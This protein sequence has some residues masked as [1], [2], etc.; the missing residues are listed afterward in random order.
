M[1][2]KLFSGFFDRYLKVIVLLMAL[3]TL[4]LLFFNLYAGLAAALITLGLFLLSKFVFLKQERELAAY[5]ENITE[6]MELAFRRFLEQHPLPLC[7]VDEEDNLLWCNDKFI[8]IYEKAEM[9]RSN[10]MQ[11][12]GV[13][14]ADFA[15]KNPLRVQRKDRS[16]LVSRVE[17]EEKERGVSMLYWQECSELEKLRQQYEDAA[18]CVAYVNVDNYDE[19]MGSASEE[20]RGVLM[21][22]L[23][24]SIRQWVSQYEG[25]AARVSSSQYCVMLQQK[26]LTKLVNTRFPI[27]GE[28]RS[29]ETEADFPTSLSIGV[30]CGRQTLSQLDQYALDALELALGRGG[31]QAV[32][33]SP[34]RIDYYGG[35]LQSVERRNKGRSRIMAHAL[36]QMIDR[37]DKVVV[38]GH[39]MPDPDCFG[40][41]M[42]LHRAAARCGKETLIVRGDYENSMERFYQAAEESGQY[43]FVLPEQAKAAMS[44]KTL[45]IVVDAHRPVLLEGK[46][47]LAMTDNIMLIDHH[48]RA[49]DCID[50]A[51]LSY[52]E[53]YASSTSE[54]VVEILQYMGD[55]KRPL[56]K[57]E[58]EALLAGIYIDTKGFSVK[59]GARTFEAAS[60]L[61][62]NGADMS[63]V[64]AFLQLDMDVYQARSAAV[65][66]AELL[67]NGVAVSYYDTIDPQM[68]LYAA[69]AADA[70]LDIAGVKAS[71]VLGQTEE[72]R[73]AVS[74]RSLGQI[75]VQLA[76]E[77][78]GGGGH[79]SM[80]GA[81]LECP[82]QEA[83]DR[84]RS[85]AATL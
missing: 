52:M 48:R 14:T 73:V 42:G 26:N 19:L 8:G 43:H 79:L 71:I 64:R 34:E 74:A 85:L 68:Q 66:R 36:R 16:F 35:Q 11:L 28:I 9:F 10:L 3:F 15:E 81:Q 30:G 53:S 33:K 1:G 29:I 47:L 44:E 70:L 2:N 58:A 13:R 6:S 83:L 23:E 61:K 40:A 67:P 27:L 41:A 18:L 49:E 60:W 72:G 75:N 59:A 31:D 7:M 80:A 77:E 84:V 69:L 22:Q 78:L 45:L 82:L 21:L 39:R 51:T 56:E 54:L 38:M 76:M 55:S 62:R 65:C 50:Y 25:T 57:L 17:I 4:A 46:E 5:S 37:A 63:E 12:A 24:K 32:V 20:N